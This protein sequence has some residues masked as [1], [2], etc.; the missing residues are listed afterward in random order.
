MALA[1]SP[2]PD[3]LSELPLFQDLDQA[4]LQTLTKHLRYKTFRAGAN[5]FS[6][7]QPGEVAYVIL[8]GTVKIFAEQ[9]DGSEVII[10]FRGPGDIIGEMSVM[11]SL[12]RS[13]SVVALEPCE[14][15]WIDRET[16][17]MCLKAMP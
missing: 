8:A 2:T 1:K 9:N 4:D 13:A 14:V 11:D 16:L 7:D 3:G 5:I 6:L 17:K 10:A 15:Y 12:G